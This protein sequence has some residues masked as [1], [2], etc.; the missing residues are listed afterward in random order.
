MAVTS[1]VHHHQLIDNSI[2]TTK[3]SSLKTAFLQVPLLS[4]VYTVYV[5]GRAL[6]LMLEFW[7][8]H[9]QNALKFQKEDT[10]L[11]MLASHCA[12]SF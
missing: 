6:H 10:I 11:L 3:Y 4:T 5:V 2:E 12:R 7:M 1:T 8:M 9:F